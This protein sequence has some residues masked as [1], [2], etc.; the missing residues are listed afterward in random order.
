MGARVV[1]KS[2]KQKKDKKSTYQ[3]MR[4]KT[5]WGQKT[6]RKKKDSLKLTLDFQ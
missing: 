2:Q 5:G 1:Q 6:K 4:L 3:Q